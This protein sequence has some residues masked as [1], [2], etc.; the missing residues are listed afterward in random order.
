M[1]YRSYYQ[2]ALELMAL[3]MDDQGKNIERAAR[4]LADTIEKDG[5]VYVFGC[6]HSHMMA[7]EMFYRAGGLAPVSAILQEDLMLHRS[8]AN[9]SR[10]EQTE[11][12]TPPLL[13]TFGATKNDVLLVVSSSGVNPA[14]I[15]M[16]LAARGRGMT[17]IGIGSSAYARETPRHSS[18]KLLYQA[19]DLFLD[20]HTPLGDACIKT[21]SGQE[22]GPMSTLLSGLMVNCIVTQT[23]E[24]LEARGVRAPLYQ[25]GNIAGGC[26]ANRALIERY[27]GR[28]RL[29]DPDN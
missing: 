15:D 3:V 25:S 23:V 20:N 29:L 27:R 14:P 6:G 18:G 19:V 17:A 16:A 2:K 8:A 7:E 26:E 4:I 21:G 12:F 1:L 9:S 24:E 22:T 13:D 5:L 28:I 10:M 11:G